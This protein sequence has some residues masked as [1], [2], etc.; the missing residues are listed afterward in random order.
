LVPPDTPRQERGHGK[1]CARPGQRE[2]APRQDH[3]DVSIIGE[4]RARVDIFPAMF[5][6][7]EPDRAAL[8]VHARMD[9][10]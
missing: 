7:N 3:R 9:N 10:P 4:A 1:D 6:K 2:G 5:A 8:E